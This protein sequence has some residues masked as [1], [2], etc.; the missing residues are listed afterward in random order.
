MVDNF[1][2]RDF[3][4]GAQV[5]VRATPSASDP[6]AKRVHHKIE[7]HTVVDPSAMLRG[8][9]TTTD[10][11][12][13]ALLNIPVDT[14][15][16]GLRLYVTRVKVVNSGSTAALITL[17][18]GSGGAV[19]GYLYV[20]A[21]GGKDDGDYFPVPLVCSVETDLYFA[22]DH[23]SSTISADAQGYKA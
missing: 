19:L 23:A 15:D 10:T 18:D 4:T 11:A 2:I 5:P 9:A 1:T 3:G 12:D 16:A 14:A 7:E 22:A 21:N 6:T 8:T 20:E 17:K 13:H